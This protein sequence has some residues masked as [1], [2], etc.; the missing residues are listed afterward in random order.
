MQRCSDKRGQCYPSRNTIARDCNISTVTVDA[1]L[2]SLS[3]NG[4][5]HIAHRYDSNGQSSNLYTVNPI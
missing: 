4:Y 3:D 2:K 5:I 1:A